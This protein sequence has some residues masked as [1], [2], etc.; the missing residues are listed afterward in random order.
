MKEKQ[1]CNDA[2]KIKKSI[3][4]KGFVQ[5]QIIVFHLNVCGIFLKSSLSCL[6]IY[7]NK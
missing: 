3:E 7:E 6:R 1:Y 4:K 5:N 2:K